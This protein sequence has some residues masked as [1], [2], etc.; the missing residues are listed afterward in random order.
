MKFFSYKSYRTYP[1]ESATKTLYWL[2]LLFYKAKR[3]N[4]SHSRIYFQRWQ[5]TYTKHKHTKLN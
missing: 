2:N 1:P 4:I 3:K 5:F